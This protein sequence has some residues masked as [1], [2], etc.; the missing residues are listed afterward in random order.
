MNIAFTIT[1]SASKIPRT[2]GPNIVAAPINP[3]DINMKNV[4]SFMLYLYLYLKY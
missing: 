1:P 2:T 3:R 4:I